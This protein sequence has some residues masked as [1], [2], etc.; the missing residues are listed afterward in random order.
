MRLEHATSVG[1]A[2]PRCTS[3]DGSTRRV[4]LPNQTSRDPHRRCSFSEKVGAFKAN[5]RSWGP[6]IEHL[7]GRLSN[8]CEFLPSHARY[9][10]AAVR[11]EK[12]LA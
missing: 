5:F 11:G 12:E 3:V 8:F 1:K 7:P 2:T 4:H 6:R 10:A 9:G